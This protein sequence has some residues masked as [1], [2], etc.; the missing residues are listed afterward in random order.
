MKNVTLEI[1]CQPTTWTW[2]CT[3][4]MYPIS[5]KRNNCT[6]ESL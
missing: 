6:L 1:N 4:C 2:N 5:E 3:Y